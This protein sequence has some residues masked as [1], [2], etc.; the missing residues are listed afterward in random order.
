MGGKG[1]WVMS[2]L[3]APGLVCGIS[4]PVLVFWYV[5]RGAAE[6]ALEV[7]EL[8]REKV[9]MLWETGIRVSL[10]TEDVHKLRA[11]L[12]LYFVSKKFRFIIFLLC[13]N[14]CSACKSF[15]HCDCICLQSCYLPRTFLAFK[16]FE[17]QQKY[18][19]KPHILVHNVMGFSGYFCCRHV[20]MAPL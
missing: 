13:I 2:V 6:A 7:Q 3:G 5:D 9:W 8:V 11:S 10:T 19:I 15:A 1:L 17:W 16:G 20:A 18:E 4:S 14:G 12:E